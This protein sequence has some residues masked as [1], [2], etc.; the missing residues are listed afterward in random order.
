MGSGV[1]GAT[2]GAVVDTSTG[3]ELSGNGASGELI[4]TAARGD[5]VGG[6]V[7]GAEATNNFRGRRHLTPHISQSHL[8]LPHKQH[9]TP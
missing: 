6:L 5:V 2:T 1:M 4:G 7:T 8:S 3:G 9:L